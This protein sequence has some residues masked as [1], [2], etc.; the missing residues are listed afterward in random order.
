MHARLLLCA[1]LLAVSAPAAASAE[2]VGHR[3]A[4]A[5]HRAKPARAGRHQTRA[6]LRRV[7]TPAPAETPRTPEPNDPRWASAWGLRALG[8]PAVWRW[9]QGSPHVV[10]A[11]VD[12]GVD[13]SQ[14]DLAG[15]LVAGWNALDGSG[16][17]ADEVGHGTA[18]AGVI[19]ARAD[20]GLGASG[21]CAQCSVMPVK[22]IDATGH[23]S[24]AA[25]AAGIE[26]AAVHGASIIN[27]SL[28][29]TAQDPAVSAAVADA[30][31]RGAVVVAAAGNDGGVAAN[32]PAAEPGV[33]SVAASDPSDGLYPWSSRGDWV[34]VSA[35]GCNEATGL[36]GSFGEFCGTSS[37]TAA[38][39]G[40]L[41][42]ALSDANAPATDVRAALLATATGGPAR[43]VEAEPL[44]RAVL[45]PSTLS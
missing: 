14:P 10:V 29:L 37:A 12:T 8:V 17:T 26:W 3:T 7:R 41:A 39:S 45:R 11:V 33:I 13:A 15:A 4:P 23:G 18:V 28:V 16:E 36:A 30:L 22:V 21:Y 43:R 2:T 42:L 20:N 31:A 25:L 19:A 6:R 32:Y 40:L 34:S 35:P 38:V 44:I 1:L 27:V 24:A 5:A 9:G